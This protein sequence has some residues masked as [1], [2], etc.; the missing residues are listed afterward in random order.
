MLT[1]NAGCSQENGHLRGPRY[2]RSRHRLGYRT[3]QR[4]SQCHNVF[5]LSPSCHS[6][7][8]RATS[9][10]LPNPVVPLAMKYA[11][12]SADVIEQTTIMSKARASTGTI[13]QALRSAHARVFAHLPLSETA[14]ATD[15][16]AITSA[17]QSE[18]NQWFCFSCVPVLTLLGREQLERPPVASPGPAEERLSLPSRPAA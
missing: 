11:K 17:S 2:G 15:T 18:C 12:L 9:G 14:T 7:W 5:R 4:D 10:R 6:A 16:I 3:F 13:D 8:R 1:V